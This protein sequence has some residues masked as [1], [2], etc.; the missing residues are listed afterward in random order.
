MSTKRSLTGFTLIELLVVIA[1]IA[2]LAAILFPVFARAREKAR[3]T[4]C[5]SN[6]RQISIAASMYAQ[7]N[8]ETLPTADVFWSGIN[9]TGDVTRCPDAKTTPGYAFNVTLSGVALGDVWNPELE[10]V[11]LDGNSVS[12]ATFVTGTPLP[13]TGSVA[14]CLTG[15]PVVNT[16]YV[17]SDAAL[18]HGT[19]F[20]AGYLDGHTT[21]TNT[22]PATDINWGTPVNATATYPAYSPSSPHTGSSVTANDLTS[23]GAWSAQATSDR[24]L[25]QGMVK[26]QF[27][28]SIVAQSV[29][30]LAPTSMTTFAAATALNF[31]LYG[32]GQSVEIWES[33]TQQTLQDTTY[34]PNDVFTIEHF[35]NA[36]I[37]LKN[38]E[39]LRTV[40]CDPSLSS[41]K[42]YT[43]LNTSPTGTAPNQ[44]TYGIGNARYYGAQ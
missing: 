32:N 8:A 38:T 27:T 7:D 23:S 35:G 34:T 2:I 9:L 22:T 24:A 11:T 19:Q 16:Y 37:Y 36:I 41:M 13:T 15:N 1:I 44:V 33:S 30:G 20:I 6:Q 17:P 43:F 10:I 31:C 5:I 42:V 39:V 3:Q 12:G 28:D 14:N 29:I 18:R 40:A 26:F 21:L 4:T 25:N